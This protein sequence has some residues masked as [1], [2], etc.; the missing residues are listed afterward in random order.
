MRAA[1]VRALLSGSA[2]TLPA[3]APTHVTGTAV[4]APSYPVLGLEGAEAIG[5]RSTFTGRGY[6]SAVQ[7]VREYI[8]AGDIFQANLSQ[9]FEAPLPEAPLAFYQRLRRE[10]P[11]PFGAYL[12]CDEVTV[13][14]DG[15]TVVTTARVGD[16]VDVHIE[17]SR[18]PVS[19]A[20]PG[21][22]LLWTRRAGSSPR[23]R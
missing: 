20:V 16:S 3:A 22:D 2:G 23:G 4:A 6:L 9:R 12:A 7:R 17:A 10:N 1:E 5:L 18:S 21:T 8:L 13:L 15:A 14:R 19:S 11:A